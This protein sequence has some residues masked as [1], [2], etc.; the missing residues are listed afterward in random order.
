MGEFLGVCISHHWT[1]C[2]GGR[3]GWRDELIELIV[4]MAIDSTPT[5]ASRL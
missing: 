3:Y 5:S 2:A 4:E 1:A